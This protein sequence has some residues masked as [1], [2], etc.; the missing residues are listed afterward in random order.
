MR[1][2]GIKTY[3]PLS[4]HGPSTRHLQCA[5]RESPVGSI[6]HV[7]T[8]R[9]PV[10]IY[11]VSCGIQQKQGRPSNLPGVPPYSIVKYVRADPRCFMHVAAGD[12]VC[13]ESTRAF[14]SLMSK[15]NQFSAKLLSRG[16]VHVRIGERWMPI[17]NIEDAY[18]EEKQIQ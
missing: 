4:I 10:I 7:S 12:F 18:A 9:R 13:F 1:D 5:Q 11:M 2:G 6:E 16:T 17:D 8:L 14:A 3:S 15:C